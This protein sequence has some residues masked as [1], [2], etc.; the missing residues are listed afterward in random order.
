M[1]LPPPARPV[2]QT[3]W[4][5]GSAS[6]GQREI[7]EEMPVAF[8]Y[9]RVA[10]AVMLATPA[11]LEDFAVGFSLTESIVATPSEIEELT[12]VPVAEGVELRMW[13]GPERAA[14]AERRRRRLAGPSGCGLCGIESLAEAAR[15]PASVAAGAPFSAG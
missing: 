3:V 9:N 12:V 14:V 2:T 10:L 13:L 1:I 6:S 15:P 7:P 4:R 5:S 8:S 11:D